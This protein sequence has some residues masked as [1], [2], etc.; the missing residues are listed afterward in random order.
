MR[1][2]ARRLFVAIELDD[3]AR[4]AIVVLQQHVVHARGAARSLTIV[5]PARMHLTLAF[6]GDVGETAVPAVTDTLS[7]NINVQPFVAV[8]H[9]LGVFPPRGAPRILWLGVGE[10]AR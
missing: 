7:V 9:G 5:D 6:L 4:V 8:F 1:S 3:A 10:G 2:P